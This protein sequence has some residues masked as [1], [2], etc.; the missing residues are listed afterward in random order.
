VPTTS[1]FPPSRHEQLFSFEQATN[2]LGEVAVP[3]SF[4]QCFPVEIQGPYVIFAEIRQVPCRRPWRHH[5]GDPVPA[6][7]F[8]PNSS[9]PSDLDRTIQNRK[10]PFAA[11]FAKE[12]LNF[13]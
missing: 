13:L 8:D 5:A 9:Q 12:T 4:S 7:W 10:Y 1:P 2:N 11:L 6:G 3:S